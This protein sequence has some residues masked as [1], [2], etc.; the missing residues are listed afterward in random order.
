M[1]KTNK[2]IQFEYSIYWFDVIHISLWQHKSVRE[3]L[4]DEDNEGCTPLH[5]ACKLG[6]PESVRSM[7]GLEVSPNHKSKQKKSAL[8]FAAE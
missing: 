8:H 4:C 5:Y 6:V 3:L 2:L 7:L 1:L